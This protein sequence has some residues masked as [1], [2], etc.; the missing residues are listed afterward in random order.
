MTP[1]KVNA[2]VIV[3]TLEETKISGVYRIELKERGYDYKVTIWVN[4]FT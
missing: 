3:N 2:C 4:T 1:E